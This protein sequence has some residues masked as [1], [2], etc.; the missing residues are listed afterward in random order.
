[1]GSENWD[2]VTLQTTQECGV[3]PQS[4]YSMGQ[5]MPLAASNKATKKSAAGL[6]SSDA[7]LMSTHLRVSERYELRM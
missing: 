3:A 6:V 4:D 7:R 2:L 5:L 1:M